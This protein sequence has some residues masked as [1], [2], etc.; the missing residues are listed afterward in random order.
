VP[1]VGFLGR[2]DIRGPATIGADE[3]LTNLPGVYVANRYNFSADQ[4]IS[5]RGPGAALTSAPAA[6]D[7]AR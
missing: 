7:P 3:A 2:T 4:R 1:A 5:I 6:E